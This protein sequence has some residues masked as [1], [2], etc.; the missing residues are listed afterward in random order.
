MVI[1]GLV[2]FFAAL[3]NAGS[4][5]RCFIVVVL[6]TCLADALVRQVNKYY[7]FFGGGDPLSLSRENAKYV[8]L[9][10]RFSVVIIRIYYKYL[11]F[12]LCLK[13]MAYIGTVKGE[14]LT[15]PVQPLSPAQ[16]SPPHAF[17][18]KTCHMIKKDSCSF[19]TKISGFFPE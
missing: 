16:P 17:R 19:K 12:L 2:V 18:V 8:E 3:R 5:W 9:W 10:I 6:P 4:I 15:H 11:S 13:G 14:G 7:S 1:R